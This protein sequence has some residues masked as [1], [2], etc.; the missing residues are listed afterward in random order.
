MESDHRTSPP[1][2][3]AADPADP[4]RIPLRRRIAFA[5]IFLLI[6]VGGGE[7]LCRLFGLGDALDVEHHVSEWHETPDGRTFWVVRGQG[8]NRDGMR[9]RAHPVDKPDGVFR[10][11]CLGDSV[12]VGHGLPRTQSY[13]FL[14]ESFY[15]QMNLPIEVMNVAVSG[16]ATLQ[17]SIAYVEV[18][19]KYDPD[20]VFLGFCLNDVAEMHNNLSEPPNAIIQGLL[21]S[22]ALARWIVGAKEREVHSVRELFETPEP[23]AVRDGWNR[24]AESLSRLQ[25]DT[26]ADGCAL[27]V[28]IFPFRFQMAPDAPE[29]IA[30]RRL[31]AMCLE[32][33]IPCLDL[34]PALLP[35][36]ESAFID[37]SHLS[38]AGARVV[39]EEII[40]WGRSGCMMCGLDLTKVA[41]EA[42]PRCGQ[43][44]ER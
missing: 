9:D 13:P 3:D 31:F 27:S 36:G 38:L 5:T 42:C 41:G 12:T 43:P 10:I 44:I 35:L 37:E 19:R 18:V 17:Q 22:S 7:L 16:W 39:A 40:R 30:Q 33:G 2:S 21:R 15:E 28:L 20:H 29:P 14:L 1:P 25:A 24:V 26:L 6:F 4:V 23:P 8:Y 34:R 11:V 32:R